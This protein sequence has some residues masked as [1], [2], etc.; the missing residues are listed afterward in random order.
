[1]IAFGPVPSRR[2]GNSLGINNIPYKICP[3]SCVYCQVGR[4]RS[5]EIERS[6]FHDPDEIRL[7]VE[8]AIEQAAARGEKID[9]L[10]FVPDGEPALDEALGRSIEG[11]KRF[12]IPVAVI[13]NASLIWEASVR[14]D[15]AKA[16]WVSLK[17]DS[18]VPEVW[19]RVNRPRSILRLESILDGAKEFARSFNGTLATETMLVSGINDHEESVRP[20]AEFVAELE[21][22]ISYLSIPTRPP[23]EKWVRPPSE[24][25]LAGAFAVASEILPKVEYLIGY[26][27]NEFASSGD[28]AE[29][30]LSI[31]AVHPMRTDAVGAML[32]RTSNEWSVVED[33]VESGRLAE[34][35]YGQQTFFLRKFSGAGRSA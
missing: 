6:R 1:M 27:G 32:R 10:T 26:E 30:L 3:Y 18:V 31:T 17:F 5:F 12:G 11:L 13:S 19:R 9:Y 8:P 33:L 25:A 7:E 16:D 29:D 20:T 14:A 15:L 23:A 28:V 22:D 21:A 34:V 2:L 35:S 4:T 24:Q